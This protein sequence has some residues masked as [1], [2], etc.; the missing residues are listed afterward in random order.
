MGEYLPIIYLNPIKAAGFMALCPPHIHFPSTSDRPAS[1][2]LMPEFS[3]FVLMVQ[4]MNLQGAI[5]QAILRSQD[6]SVIWEAADVN[7]PSSLNHL[8][9][10]GLAL[11]DLLLIDTRVQT[12]NVYAFCRWCQQNCPD[13]K[14][15]LV[16]GAQK[17]ITLSEREW[18]IY[19]GAADLLPRF[20]RDL[21]VSGAVARTRR[22]LDLLD[23]PTLNQGRLVA[24][25][26]AVQRVSPMGQTEH[27]AR[28]HHDEDVL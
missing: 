25:L 16:N 4:P 23:C 8:Q 22:I 6:L 28:G 21:L 10:A 26:L 18:A 13:V 3:K 12:F 19:Q 7:L 15:V 1:T 20:Q 24:A 5:W 17:E 11:P 27:V 9:R 14:V 2:Y